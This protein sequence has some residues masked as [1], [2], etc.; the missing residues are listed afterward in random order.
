[1]HC[2]PLPAVCGCG[3]KKEK[4]E[5]IKL[6]QTF[7]LSGSKLPMY[8]ARGWREEVEGLRRHHAYFSAIAGQSHECNVGYDDFWL[9]E[10]Q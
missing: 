6:L 8:I 4:K 10:F 2:Y 5:L 1:M 7:Q 3:G 9:V